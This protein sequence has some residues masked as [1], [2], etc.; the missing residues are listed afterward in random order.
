[1]S[2]S[3]RERERRRRHKLASKIHAK[4][5]DPDE[6]NSDVESAFAREHGVVFTW[7]LKQPALEKMGIDPAAEMVRKA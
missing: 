1:V 6:D 7:M 4:L 3:N 5:A 2:N